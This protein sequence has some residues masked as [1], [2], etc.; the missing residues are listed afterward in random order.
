MPVRSAAWL[1]GS[2]VLKAV[3]DPVRLR[4]MLAENQAVLGVARMPT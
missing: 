2:S 3:A 1:T 4:G